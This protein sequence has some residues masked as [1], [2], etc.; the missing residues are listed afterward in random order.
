[1]ANSSS[2]RLLLRRR[3]GASLP[4]LYRLCAVAL[5]LSLGLGVAITF[6]KL[7]PDPGLAH[8]IGSE[9]V[10]T[11]E[12]ANWYRAVAMTLLGLTAVGLIYNRLRRSVAS[13]A[14]SE[15]R[16]RAV[17]DIAL[18]CIIS[19]DH[20][21][22]VLEFNPAAERT[23]GYRRA[24][25]LGRDFAAL[26]VP[27]DQ[28]EAHLRGMK[29]Y[30]ATG[31]G[32]FI[33]RR[34]EVMAMRA[35]G[36]QFPAELAIEAIRHGGPPVFTAYVRD[37]SDRRRAAADLADRMRLTQ[38][39]A[40]VALGVTRA[41]SMGEMLQFSCQVL[42]DRLGA[43]VARVW[44]LDSN[45]QVL[46][47]QAS[48][49]LYTHLDGAHSRI[50]VGEMKIGQIAAQRQ[51]HVTNSVLVDSRVSDRQWASREGMVAFAG[52]P[53]IVGG[54]LMGVMA[55]FSRSALPA[56]T[57]EVLSVIAD[58]VALG[59]ER[60]EA[61][62]GL[63]LAAQERALALEA[64]RAKGEFLARMSHEIRTP[65]NSILGYAELMRRGVAPEEHETFIETIH[66]SGQ[67]LLSLIDD[68]LDLSKIE[69]GR[70]NFERVRCSPH[71]VISEVLSLLRVRAHEKGLSLDCRWTSGVP[72]TILTDPARLRQLLVNLVGN[73]IKFTDRGGVSLV[74]SISMERPDPRFVIE[75]RDTGIGIP[76]QRHESIFLPFEQGDGSAT[77][78]FGGTGLG[79]AISRCLAEGLGG[80][81][82]VDSEL[83]R[84]SVFRLTIDT[85][86]LD[87]V[88]MLESPPTEALSSGE[89]RARERVRRLAGARVLLVEDGETNRQLIRLVLEEAGVEVVCAENG[90]EGL[91][92]ASRDKFDLI[93]MDM[94]MP[95][96][97]G[98][99]ATCR[100]RER[101]CQLPIIAL[102]AHAMRGDKEKCFAAGCSGYLTK[103]VN[104]DALLSTVGDAL[105]SK[106]N[107]ENS[108]R[109]SGE[110][111]Q[112]AVARHDQA[113]ITGALPLE[114][115]RYQK[116][117][118]M[119]VDRLDRQLEAMQSA[120]RA[121]NWDDLALLAH[122]L[123]G[124]GG[125]VG[126]GCFTEPAERL[127]RLAKEHRSD[128]IQACLGEL[129]ALAG[130]ITVSA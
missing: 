99:A 48:A 82:T 35:V 60:F 111:V 84:G 3:L 19:I 38:L 66:S 8:I 77:R 33:G 93:L 118:A 79:L 24:D 106:P 46:E 54:R 44:T 69:A 103:P 34:V 14:E 39:T 90:L 72:E 58:T 10:A 12:L 55:M 21:G 97:D 27:P 116:I 86:P 78:R 15:V 102:T 30:L 125:T 11:R 56:S 75:V 32:A 113:T 114:P 122:W 25:V 108:G 16:L 17:I 115:T 40:D 43:A 121:A 37:V 71:Q 128:D 29:R 7:R 68:I 67:H 4:P 98:Y 100:L 6:W 88:R 89:T 2:R 94:Q 73:A 31:Q 120:A 101:G 81:I 36:T 41:D 124:A 45:E 105:G 26:I 70:M 49:G 51:P 129:T 74:A 64:S 65:L 63:T 92:L 110:F 22:R 127:E 9:Q 119:F 123:K 87:D 13:L 80:E 47:L 18:D 76:Q 107:V 62:R 104:I 112:Q 50:A 95:L 42:V 28:H 130:R 23:F 1:M 59:I 83:G 109:D 61:E 126:F 91:S 20:T 52:Y 117:V 57:I 96:M 85:G 5:L 53:L